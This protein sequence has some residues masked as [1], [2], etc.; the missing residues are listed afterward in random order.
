MIR[1]TSALAA[2]CFVLLVAGCRR[3]SGAAKTDSAAADSIRDAHSASDTTPTMPAG[4]G[5]SSSVDS[6]RAPINS[7]EG[8]IG[9][10][11]KPHAADTMDRDSVIPGPY[12]TMDS[13]GRI[14]R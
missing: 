10:T 3:D 13:I 1:R 7:T 14:K 9:E 8:T 2:C 6:A 12:K 4:I 5:G 11:R